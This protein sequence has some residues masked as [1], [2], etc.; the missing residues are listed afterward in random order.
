M[1][2]IVVSKSHMHSFAGGWGV[3][4]LVEWRFKN[5][6]TRRINGQ[7]HISMRFHGLTYPYSMRTML[8]QKESK[9]SY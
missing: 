1:L 4:V 3:G 8:S 6:P 5:V 2:S 9:T 7:Q